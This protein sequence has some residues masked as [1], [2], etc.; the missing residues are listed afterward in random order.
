MQAHAFI[1]AAA[2]T[3]NQPLFIK[4]DEVNIQFSPRTPEQ[5]ASFYIAR[6][7][8]GEVVDVL[9]QQCFI[10]IRIH[11]TGKEKLWL[12]L[13]NWKFSTDGKPLHRDHRNVWKQRWSDMDVPLRFQSTF[14]WTLL[15]ESLDYLPHEEE[16]GNIILPRVK[17]PV[18]LKASFIT[19]NDKQGPVINI[20][21]DKLYCAEDPQ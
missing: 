16:G 4:T 13:A 2:A 7:F 12:D 3:I 18:S 8:P 15:P 19:G 21:Y 20:E 9:K 10:T 17:G 11:N 5:I 6:G 14:R 1:F